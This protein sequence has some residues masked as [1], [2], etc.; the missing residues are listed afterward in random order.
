MHGNLSSSMP[1]CRQWGED[2]AGGEDPPLARMTADCPISSQCRGF[3]VR[4]LKHIR[5]ALGGL[6][7]NRVHQCAETDQLRKKTGRV[8]EFPLIAYLLPKCGYR[9]WHVAQRRGDLPVNR[10]NQPDPD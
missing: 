8:P 6:N 10:L 5:Q 1:E 4:S 9:I 3:S 2:I 7:Q